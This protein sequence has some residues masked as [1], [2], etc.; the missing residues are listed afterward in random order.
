VNGLQFRDGPGSTDAPI[1]AG[2][3]LIQADEVKIDSRNGSVIVKSLEIMKPS[4]RAY[5][6]EKGIHA[7][8]LL[9]PLK[10]A[11]TQPTTGAGGADAGERIGVAG[12]CAPRSATGCQHRRSFQC[13]RA[14]REVRIDRFIISGIDVRVEDRSV[15]P[16]LI[17][18][19]NNL[20]VD[21]RG[22]TTLALSEPRTIRFDAVVN[23]DKVPLPARQKD[24]GGD[25]VGGGIFGKLG[26]LL[27]SWRRAKDGNHR[28]SH[29]A[30]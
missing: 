1:L 29:G 5:R 9:I 13:G 30:A 26:G 7:L 2:V 18:P 14:H 25:G 11:A 8:G 23:A 4:A 24:E 10:A 17:V 22:F 6:D 28:A 20:D 16:P 15:E 21:V 27:H 12:G 3:D 19:L